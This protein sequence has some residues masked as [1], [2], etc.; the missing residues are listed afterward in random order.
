[1]L[2]RRAGGGYEGRLMDGWRVRGRGDGGR[3][4]WVGVGGK[5]GGREGG[6]RG[7]SFF[8]ARRVDNERGIALLGGDEC[9]IGKMNHEW[10]RVE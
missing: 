2:G 3:E 1:M 8:C 7:G 6:I 9:G 5:E 10:I 4:R